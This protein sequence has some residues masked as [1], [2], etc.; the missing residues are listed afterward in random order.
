MSPTDESRKKEPKPKTLKQVVWFKDVLR[1]SVVIFLYSCHP[2]LP[3]NLQLD[4]CRILLG[5]SETRKAEQL[6]AA[7]PVLPTVFLFSPS[8][9]LWRRLSLLFFWGLLIEFRRLDLAVWMGLTT[10]LLLFHYRVNP[11]GLFYGP[12]DSKWFSNKIFK[13][14]HCLLTIANVWTLYLVSRFYGK[15][16]SCQWRSTQIS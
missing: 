13:Q 5:I 10:L 12:H 15:S 7:A 8:L 4:V 1:N 6:I 2:V 11:M 9:Q 16:Y 14:Q 3:S